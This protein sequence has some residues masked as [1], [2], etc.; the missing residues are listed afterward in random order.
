MGGTSATLLPLPSLSYGCS[1]LPR[2]RSYSHFVALRAPAW[3][4]VASNR[5][6]HG[7]SPQPGVFEDNG[8]LLV[9]GDQAGLETLLLPFAYRYHDFLVD[10]L[11]GLG[12]CVGA[13]FLKL[14]G[15]EVVRG[16]H[17]MP[18]HGAV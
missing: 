13:R 18:H 16:V 8:L 5:Q 10:D 7:N 2:G 6:I 12:V 11:S 4:E 3:G 1:L 15:H 9:A 14:C 17:H